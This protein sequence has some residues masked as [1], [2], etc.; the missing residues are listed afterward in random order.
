MMEKVLKDSKNVLWVFQTGDFRIESNT[1]WVLVELH[2]S[3]DQDLLP[4][5]KKPPKNRYKTTGTQ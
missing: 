4:Q 5:N 2:T 1:V 3:F